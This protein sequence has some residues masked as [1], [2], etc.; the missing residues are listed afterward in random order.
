MFP[1]L[2][3]ASAKVKAGNPLEGLLNEIRQIVLSIKRSY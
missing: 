3:I 1:R 2:S